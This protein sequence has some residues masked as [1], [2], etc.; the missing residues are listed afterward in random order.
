MNGAPPTVFIVDDD[1]AVLKSLARLLWS[2]RLNVATFAS[3]REFL[4]AHDP[5]KPGCLLLDIS[6]PGVNGL[7]LQQALARMGSA[8]P[9]VFITGHGDIPTSVNAMKRGA[10][11]FLTKPVDD[12]A[13]IEAVQRG[14]EKDRAT[15][16]TNGKVRDV[17]SRMA[18]LTPRERE[19]LARVVAGKLNRE[20]AVELGI[21]EKTI[22]VHRGRVME[23][24]HAASL[25]DL[26]RQAELAGSHG[27]PET[28][29]GI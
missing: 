9:I 18:T 21:A 20:I 3:P 15:R 22:K 29:D 4:D 12:Q 28:N 2:A 5:G 16:E 26:V 17:R 27:A 6:M 14:L 8:T 7:E 25:A 11:D 24:M 23:K 13:L 1:H 10:I 19:V